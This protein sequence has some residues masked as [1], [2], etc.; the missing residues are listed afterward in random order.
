MEPVWPV[1][2]RL[3]CAKVT[4]SVW[5]SS[6]LC[7]GHLI[8]VDAVWPVWIPSGLSE[9][10]LVRL[11]AIWPMWMAVWSVSAP[12]GRWGRR[13]VLRE[14]RLAFVEAAGLFGIRQAC[15]EAAWPVCRPPGLCGGHLFCVDICSMVWKA[16]YIALQRPPVQCGSRPSSRVARTLGLQWF[17]PFLK[18]DSFLHFQTGSGVRRPNSQHVY[19]QLWYCWFCSFMSKSTESPFFEQK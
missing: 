17:S 15:V 8:C 6:V 19:F 16:V 7:G 2:N 4:R 1:W 11:T 3:T 14:C 13:F 12:S 10:S 18:T 9:D 5:M